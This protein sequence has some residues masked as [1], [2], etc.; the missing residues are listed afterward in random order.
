MSV[1]TIFTALAAFPAAAIVTAGV[2]GALGV[3]LNRRPHSVYVPRPQR[4]PLARS[5]TATDTSCSSDGDGAAATWEDGKPAGRVAAVQLLDAWC[6]CPRSIWHALGARALQVT[7]SE[8][9]ARTVSQAILEGILARHVTPMDTWLVRDFA[10]TAWGAAPDD[11]ERASPAIE[12]AA[13]RAVT[14]G[15]LALMA[16]VWLPGEDFERLAAMVVR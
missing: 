11:C 16:R 3:R 10:D 4:Q 2:L 14:N 8:A 5:A 9:G 15:A 1:P 6:D 13:R 12:M 7:R